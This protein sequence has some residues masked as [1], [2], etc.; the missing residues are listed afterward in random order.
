VDA[1]AAVVVGAV[2]G[3]IAVVGVVFVERI[4]IDD[5]VGAV[6]V[7]GLAGVWGTLA[8]GLFAAP[9]LVKITATGTEGLVYSG[10]FHQLGIQLLGLA[11]VGAF[12]FSTSFAVLWTMNRIWGIRVEDEVEEGG[13]DLHEHGHEAY[14]QHVLPEGPLARPGTNGN[15]GYHTPDPVPAPA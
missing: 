6:A 14:P 9:E 2:A 1:W 8:C 15:N 10:S 11:A 5:P 4:R 12:T 13:L 3:V 7:H